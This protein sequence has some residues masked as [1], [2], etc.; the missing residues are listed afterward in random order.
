MYAM[1]QENANQSVRDYLKQ[2][3]R[4]VSSQSKSNGRIETTLIPAHKLKVCQFSQRP[5]RSKKHA[6]WIVNNFE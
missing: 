2:R 3:N 6:E 1:S 5:L 4:T